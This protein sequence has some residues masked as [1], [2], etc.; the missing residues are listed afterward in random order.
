MF[1]RKWQALILGAIVLVVVAI[2]WAAAQEMVSGGAVVPTLKQQL[3][4]GLLARTPSEN[5]FVDLVVHKVKDGDLPLSLV[6]STFLWARRKQPYPM[7]YFEQA[8]K[9]RA[10]QQGIS[11]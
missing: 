6:Q 3:Q 8:L 5:A 11:L 2:G 10:R 1:L 9:L 7:Q 4:T